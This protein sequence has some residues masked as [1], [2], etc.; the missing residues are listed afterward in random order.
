M[1]SNKIFH[2]FF[3]FL[4]CQ[5]AFG[6]DNSPDPNTLSI[7]EFISV[8]RAYHPVF[9]Q[10][11]L[12]YESSL[13][14][15]KA[16]RGGFD[17]ALQM[18]LDEKQFDQKEYFR[19]SGANLKIP[20]WYGLDFQAGLA[21]ND[22]E[23]IFPE[24][25]PGRSQYLGLKMPLLQGLAYDKRRNAVQQA[26]QMV[27]FSNE[28]RISMRNQTLFAGI[29][30][31]YDWKLWVEQKKLADSLATAN[32]LRFE[33]VRSGFFL[34]ERPAIDT[35]EALSQWQQYQIIQIEAEQKLLEARFELS[36]F[37]WLENGNYYDI[38]ERVSPP[39]NEVNLP[40]LLS[41]TQCLDQ[42]VLHPKW[43]QA[44]IKLKSLDLEKRLKF[45][46]LLPTADLGFQSLSADQ[47]LFPAQVFPQD[48]FKL[49][50]DLQI[51]LFFRQGRGEYNRAK[52]KIREQK[53]EMDILNAGLRN[54]IR[55]YHND[56][57]QFAVQ[58]NIQT[59]ATENYRQLYAA[60]LERFS[61]G[62]SSLFLINQRENKY[63]ES[64][65]KLLYLQAKSA[66]SAYG[67]SYAMGSLARE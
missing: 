51:P 56:A 59:E 46:M 4:V 14:S 41:L 55:K 17:P 42:A 25:T 50:I 12:Q 18:S 19:Y 47:R 53:L 39:E 36:N 5:L 52:I 44:G 9:R 22:G 37:L 45:Q 2:F 30:A 43:K 3:A 11:D 63:L 8:V 10:S 58:V 61:T 16:A 21:Q 6:Q 65:Q 24:L 31:Y 20:T 1:R 40:V 57:A 49:G 13:E 38:P 28:E 23:R 62:E 54:E 33:M 7:D 34:G 26:K 48:N 35:V 32:R 27:L 64:R 67:V 15:L 66:V 29:K 60:E